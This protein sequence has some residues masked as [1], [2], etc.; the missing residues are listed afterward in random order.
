METIQRTKGYIKLYS[1]EQNNRIREN[2]CPI[3][4]LPKEKWFRRKDWTCCSKKC[5]EEFSKLFTSWQYFK[6]KV[7]ER[8]NFTCV[9][10]GFKSLKKRP[11]DEREENWYKNF[12]EYRKSIENSKEYYKFL[13]WES[14]TAI[15]LTTE[16]IIADHI[17]PIAMGGEE[18]DLNNIQTLC[19]KCNKEKTK[20]DMQKIS[21]Y[22]KQSLEQ[23]PLILNKEVRKEAINLGCPS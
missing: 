7:F 2:R 1:E 21:L 10:C 9:K 17:I 12:E 5:T 13:Y 6:E 19:I 18:F 3:C 20:K 8:D 11:Y 16:Y 14:T 15:C 23:V 4:N 22:R